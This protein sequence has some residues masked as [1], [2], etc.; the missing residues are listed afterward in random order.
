MADFEGK[1][2]EIA[3]RALRSMF[4]EQDF[5]NFLHPKDH[6]DRPEV[7]IYDTEKPAAY[8]NGRALE[9]DVVDLACHFERGMPR[10]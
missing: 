3:G 8:P 1:Q 4:P 2:Q 7:V 6:G 5:L 9:D 10:I